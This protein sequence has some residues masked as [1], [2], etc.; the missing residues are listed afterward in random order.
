[1]TRILSAVVVFALLAGCSAVPPSAA[2]P[3]RSQTVRY[4]DINL[5]YPAGAA[6]LYRR[7]RVA[8]QQVCDDG[9]VV[10][11]AQRRLIIECERQA[12]DAAV[13]Q[14]NDARL[15][16]YALTQRRGTLRLAGGG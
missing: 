6:R 10:P 4:A 2:G 8:A 9:T 7:I 13:E 12:I 1:M 15:T 14:V 11:L 3:E 16:G 5:A